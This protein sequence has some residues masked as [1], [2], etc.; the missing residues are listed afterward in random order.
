[1]QVSS[2][3][4]RLIETIVPRPGPTAGAGA[5]L[6]PVRGGQL[7]RDTRLLARKNASLF[8]LIPFLDGKRLVYL[9]LSPF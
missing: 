8:G 4:K 5:R 1:M 9:D 7:S 6:N 2:L 3:V